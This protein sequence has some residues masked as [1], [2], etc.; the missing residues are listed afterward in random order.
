MGQ[1]LPLANFEKYSQI[2]A[3]FQEHLLQEIPHLLYIIFAQEW[4]LRAGNLF[5]N[6]K[7]QGNWDKMVMAF[8]ILYKLYRLGNS[9][10]KRF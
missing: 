8:L 10:S 7:F 4:N 2:T 5:E 9:F 6:L 1:L 3:D